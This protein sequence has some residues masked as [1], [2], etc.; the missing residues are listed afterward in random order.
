MN[1]KRVTGVIDYWWE[2]DD[3]LI[4]T[5]DGVTTRYTNAEITNVKE[6]APHGPGLEV[7]PMTFVGKLVKGE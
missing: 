7:I 2:G 6:T 5:D 4:T 3:F 1:E